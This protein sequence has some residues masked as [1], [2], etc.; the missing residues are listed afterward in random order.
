MESHYIIDAEDRIESFETQALPQEPR[1]VSEWKGC[2]M[3]ST[4]SGDVTREIYRR[5][6]RRVRAEQ[7]QTRFQ[8]RCDIASERRWFEM[9]VRCLDAGRVEF[10]SKLLSVCAR[11]PINW[12][13]STAGEGPSIILCSWCGQVLHEG[14]WVEAEQAAPH[15]PDTARVEHGICPTCATKF[16]A[17]F[18]ESQ[19]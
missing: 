12:L 8:Y 10:H 11:P 17:Q 13:D 4:L 6:L 15:V 2:S 7:S 16:M 19:K 1:A 9:S 5:L 14:R 3:W 18:G